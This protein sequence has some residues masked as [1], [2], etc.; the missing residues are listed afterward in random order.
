MANTYQTLTQGENRAVTITIQNQHHVA[1]TPM[2]T[3]K[4]QVTDCD[5]G[6]VVAEASAT[7]SSNAL[8]CVIGTIVTGTIGDYYIIWKIVDEDG[9]IY[10]HKTNLQISSLLGT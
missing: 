9:Y 4:Y 2:D 8:T 6:V 5:G 1:V 10:Y 3:S 7:V